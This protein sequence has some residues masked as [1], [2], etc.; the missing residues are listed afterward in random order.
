MAKT[1]EKG[2]QNGKKDSFEL[3]FWSNC[4]FAGRAAPAGLAMRRGAAKP[5]TE[6]ACWR[7]AEQT[8]EPQSVAPAVGRRPQKKSPL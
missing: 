1:Q 3:S 4:G 7:R 8:C 5:Q 2:C 6:P